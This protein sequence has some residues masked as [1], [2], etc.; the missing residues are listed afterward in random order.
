MNII[1][2]TVLYLNSGS[3]PLTV[4]ELR[5][6]NVQVAWITDLG[7]QETWFPPICLTEERLLDHY[8]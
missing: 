3:P 1:I 2:G 7:V 5:E 8:D 6:G 4:I